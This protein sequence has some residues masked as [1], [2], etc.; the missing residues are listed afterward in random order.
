MSDFNPALLTPGI[1]SER[2]IE[3]QV[4]R[5]VGRKGD[6]R[7]ELHYGDFGTGHGRQ[8]AL[9][10]IRP[11]RPPAFIPLSMLWQY[12]QKNAMQKL[13]PPLA[14]NLYGFVTK[15]DCYRISD[16]IFDYLEDLQKAPPA[17]ELG[18]QTLDAYLESCVQEG[19]DFFVEFGGKREYLT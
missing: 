4:S 9:A 16:A 3:T 1:G 2:G 19:L 17:P 13:V 6:L 5:L 8:P 11:K 12:V 15:Q 7:V 18:N 14:E 10:L